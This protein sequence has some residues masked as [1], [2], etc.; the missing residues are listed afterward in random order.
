[1][2]TC[3][4]CRAV[5][6]FR[7]VRIVDGNLKMG[8]SR[9][10]HPGAAARCPDQPFD[11]HRVTGHNPVPRFGYRYRRSVERIAGVRFTL[12]QPAMFGFPGL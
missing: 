1:M 3:R 9:R 4:V 7:A 10:N 11:V 8:R 2:A 5:E 12:G 6:L